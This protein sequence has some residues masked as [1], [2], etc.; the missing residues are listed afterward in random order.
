MEGVITL[1]QDE[2]DLITV[3]QLAD[4][5]GVTVMTAHRTLDRGDIT[6]ADTLQRGKQKVRLVRRQEAQRYKDGL[7]QKGTERSNS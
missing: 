3:P 6:V 7:E 5:L 2:T 1:T 4:L